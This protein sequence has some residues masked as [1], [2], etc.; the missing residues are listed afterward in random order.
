MGKLKGFFAIV[1]AAAFLLLVSFFPKI[2]GLFLDRSTGNPTFSPISPVRLEIRSDISPIGRLAMLSRMDSNIK[3]SESK[4]SMTKEKVL[5][6]VHNEL[7]PYL[8]AQLMVYNERDVQMQPVLVQGDSELQGIV[9]LVTVSGEQTD[10]SFLDMAIDDET[11]RILRISYTV[12][13]PTGDI[14]GMEALYLFADIFFSGLEIEDHW[15][16][17][18]PDLEYAYT[19]DG[20]DAIRF[21]F[22]DAQYG[23]I[24]VDL[25]VHDHGFY[26]EF[27]TM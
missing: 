4:A 7:Q 21:R 22:E 1:F 13:N 3:L 5:E 23:Q 20:G 19:G 25:F 14:V 2:I 18:V 10:F 17:A 15:A 9:W 24:T 27:P 8:N 6:A 16:Y 12:E 26:V 11:G